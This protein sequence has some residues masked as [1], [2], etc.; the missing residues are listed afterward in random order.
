MHPEA[1]EW[2]SRHATTD[3]ATV[4]DLGGRYINGS[5]RPL[6]P[7]AA[8]YTVLDLLPGSNVDI[9][10]DAATWNPHGRR[11][12]IVVCCEVC[13][14][15]SVWPMILGTASL[16]LRPGGRLI[17]T[18]AAP[19]RP[20]HSGIDGGE[21]RVGE[22]YANIDPGELESVLKECGFAEITVDV[23]A[24]SHDVRAIATKPVKEGSTT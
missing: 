10:A 11:W 20:P 15:T 21:V 3:S 12:D 22:W 17:V 8:A 5:P 6:F 19:G 24:N 7:N 18:T 4:L 13:E 14:H 23:E 16:A 9:V 1:Y 2:V